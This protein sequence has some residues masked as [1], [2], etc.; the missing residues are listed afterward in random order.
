L[1]SLLITQL[2]PPSLPA[3]G[4]FWI[5]RHTE[6][7]LTTPDEIADAKLLVGLR[8]AACEIAPVARRLRRRE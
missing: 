7:F 3:L 6:D 1:A 4:T 2:F 5:V 8:I